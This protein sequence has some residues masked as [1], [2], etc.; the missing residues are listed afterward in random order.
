MVCK[1]CS[2]SSESLFYSE[3][4]QWNRSSMTVQVHQVQVWSVK[5]PPDCESSQ[6]FYMEK[7]WWNNNVLTQST[8]VSGI[9]PSLLLKKVDFLVYKCQHCT[10]WHLILLGDFIPLKHNN[11]KTIQKSSSVTPIRWESWFPMPL[12]WGTSC[13]LRVCG[14]LGVSVWGVQMCSTWRLCGPPGRVPHSS[15]YNCCKCLVHIQLYR[16]WSRVIIFLI[17]LLLLLFT[18]II[19][20]YSLESPLWVWGRITFNKLPVCHKANT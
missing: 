13:Q 7:W 9:I 3:R 18:I 14:L 2:K 12:V 6:H 16:D 5:R 15:L 19:Q 8:C 1:C 17:L 10:Y 4:I 11:T 20:S